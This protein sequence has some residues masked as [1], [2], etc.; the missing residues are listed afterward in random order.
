M[1][2]TSWQSLALLAIGGGLISFLVLEGVEARGLL[3]VPVPMI[4]AAGPA[5]LA[6]VLLSLG[7]NV[8]RLVHQE[9]TSMTPLGAAR[10]VLLAKA[11]S[12]VGSVLVGYFA[13]QVLVALDNISAPLPREQ[14][15]GAGLALLACLVLVTVALL[16]EWW[17]RV[18]PD[19]EEDP[20]GAN[21]GA[22]AA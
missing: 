2:R 15:V 13:A 6:V 4:T 5:I 16:V 12:S 19:D 7:R 17:C 20:S 1:S 22:S 8:R 18:P 3:P 11:S 10:V 21:H 9:P 14:A